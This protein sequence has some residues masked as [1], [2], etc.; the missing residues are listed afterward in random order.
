MSSFVIAGPLIR[1]VSQQ[2]FALWLVVR[3]PCDLRVSLRYGVGEYQALAPTDT[4]IRFLQMGAQC[5]YA[6][7]DFTL[8]PD[9][10]PQTWVSYQIDYALEEGTWHP[11]TDEMGHV[12]YEGHDSL[13]F[14]YSPQVESLLHGSCRKPHMQSPEDGLAIADTYMASC[15]SDT[16]Q[17]PP[18]L[19]VLSGDQIYADDVAG[20]TLR[21]IHQVIEKLGLYPEQMRGLGTVELQQDQ[22]L[23]AHQKSYYARGHLLP[24]VTQNRAMLDMVFGGVEKPIFTTTTANNHLMSL[25]EHLAMYLLVWSPTLWAE[26][27]LDPPEGLSADDLQTYEQERE[28]L[29]S[30][31]AGLDKVQ[32]FLAHCPIAMIFDDHDV[33]DDWNLNRAWEEAAYGHPLSRRI[34]GNALCAYTINQGWGNAPD[35]FESFLGEIAVLKDQIG[36]K[37]YDDFL[38]RLLQYQG[39]AYRWETQPPLVVLDTRTRRWR[40]ESSA[41]KPSGLL[42][43]EALGDLQNA[44]Q[45]LDAVLLVAPAPIFGVKV[46]EVIQRL[47]TWIGKPL[48]VDAENWM[49]HPGTANC[50]LNIF[51]H[52]KTP[53]NVVILSGDVH[54]SFVYDVELRRGSSGPDVWQITSSGLRNEFPKRLLSLL[55]RINRWLYAPASPL[56]WLTRRRRMR[57]TPRK[58]EGAEDGMRLLNASGIG[59]V[60][61][62]AAGQPT[63]ITMLTGQQRRVGFTRIEGRSP[64]R[65]GLFASYDVD[66]PPVFLRSTTN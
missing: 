46:I 66:L 64:E 37:P 58:P 35:R 29:E 28:A 5:V 7:M 59:L 24:Q 8:P 38:Q 19:C 30:F 27:S 18:S 65:K 52:S 14:Y 12:C 23:Y 11:L 44:L 48:V 54:Y 33:T 41:V 17:K 50:I 34:L 1:R 56:N 2:S 21:A 40:S 22:D 60:R 53:Q 6:F 4:G 10:P 51:H 57:I 31:I 26:V 32:R 13:G 49:A 36:A 15:L 25:N 20:P 62:N 61:L 45:G 55:D 39:W 47:F 43:W 16:A 9:L 42:D 63:E 3:Q